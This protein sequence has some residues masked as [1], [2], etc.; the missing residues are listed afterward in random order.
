ML[1][2][3]FAWA[4]TPSSLPRP[5]EATNPPADTTKKSKPRFPVKTTTPITLDDTKK[6]MADLKDPDNIKEE[7]EY[8][9]HSGNYLIGTKIGGGYMNTPFMMTPQEYQEW[10]IQRS[11]RQ[12]YA[13]K[14]KEAFDNKEEKEFSF[15]NMQFS[16]GPAEKIFGPGGVQ[17][18]SSGS[19]EIKFGLNKKSVDNPSLP[20]RNRKTTG[21]DFD[22]Q[23][24]LSVL[25][26]IGDK[27]N[28]NLNY[29]TEATFD[30]DA[31]S[32][33]LQYDGKEDEIVKLIEA[34][35]VSFPSNNSLVRGSSS[36]FGIRT[37]LQFGKLQ[38]Q[39]VVSQKKGVSKSVSSSGGDQM[40]TFE[41]SADN[42]E[43]NRHFFLAHFFRDNYDK[44][45]AK[46]PNITSGITINRIEVWVTNK[47][48]TTTNTRNII[49]FTDLAESSHIGNGNWHS[50]GITQPC[51]NSNDLYSTINSSYADARVINKVYSTLGTISGFTGG[52]DY[53]KLESARLL[54]KTEY[55]LNSSLGYISL[56][57][58][59]QT[60]QVLAVAYEYTYRGQTYQVG[61]FSTDR[62]D[63]TECLYVKTLKNATNTPAMANW[64]LMMKN[65][66]SLGASSID[67]SKFRLDIKYLSDTSGVYITYL[68]TEKYKNTTLLK[69]LGMDRLD[70][71]Q[72]AHPNGYYD[73]VEGYTIDRSSGR[74]FLPAA[75]PFGSYFENII[76]DRSIS[77]NFVYNEL[78][79]STRTI[80]KQITEKNKFILTGQY[81]G[82]SGGNVI[83]L[84]AVN[85]PRG[86]VV[87]TAGGVTLTENIDYSVNYG[88]GEVTILNQSIIDAGT[89]VNVSLESTGESLERKT[90]LGLNWQY[91]FNKNFILGGTLMHL[92]EQ[93]LTSKVAMGNEPLS[94]TIMG[95]S[96][97]WKQNS[98]WLTDLIDKIPFINIT[99][100]SS[101]NFTAEFAKL[102]TGANSQSQGNASYIDDFE[103]TK[104]AID[105]SSPTDWV[106]SSCLLFF[107]EATYSNDVRY[108]YNRSLLSWYNIDPMF[109]R[110]SSSL[111]P[112]HIKSDLNQLSNH[113]VREV[114]RTELFPNKELT[115]GESSTLNILNLAY[116][117]NERGPYNLNTNLD[118]NGKL[119]NPKEHWGG[120][121]RALETTDFETAN[122]E[123]I[124]FWM[125]DPF[126]YTRG[127]AG[128]HG[129]ELYFDLG[130]ISE[131]ILKDGN[132]FY[133]SGMP[134]DGS[135]NYMES[136]WGRIPTENT[137]TY[138]FNTSSG[139]RSRQDIGYNGL[140]SD[141][142]KN[143]AIYQ[144]FL[145]GIQGK[146]SQA[147]YDSLA[148]DPAGDDYHYFRGSDYDEKRVSIMDRYKKINNPEGNSV[149]SDNSPESYSTA[150]KTIP[151]AEDI[152]QDYTLNEYNNYYEYRVRLAPD[153]MKVGAGYI[154]D[155]RQAKVPLRNGNTESISWYLFRI[156][157]EQYKSKKGNINDFS[158]IRFIR[159]FLTN[160]ENPIVLRFGTLELVRGEWR[161]YDL[162]LNGR[163][164]QTAQGT[165]DVAA[166]NI[167]ENNTKTPVNY[168]LPPG[169]SPVIDRTQSQL[170][171]NNEQALN[172]TVKRLPANESRAVYK[173]YNLDLR[174][175]KHIQMFAHANAL[176][177]DLTLKDY[178]TSV[179]IRI[180]TDYKNNYYEYDILL[181]LTAAGHYDR[182]STTDCQQ[183]W[184]EENM[185][186]IDLSL[187]TDLK[188][189]RNK[190]KA[191]G[192][193]SY[194]VPYYDYDPNKPNNKITVMGN[195]SL[196][197]IKTL[198]IGVRNN[199]HENKQVEVWVNELRLQNYSQDGGMAAR[200][201]L[202]IKISDLATISA[203]T[204][205]ETSGFG[206]LEQGVTERRNSNLYSY[207]ITSSIQLGKLFPEKA[208]V[209]API[210]YSYSKDKIVP[211]YNPLD[212][213][214]KLDDALSALPSSR[215]KDSLKNIVNTV[216][217]SK[218][219]SISNVKVDIAS[220][221]HPMPY[222]PANFSVSY[223]HSHLFS[224]GET[225]MW[226]RN[227]AWKL[228]ANYDYAP[229][230]EPFAPFKNLQDKKG[231]LR[232]L[233]EFQINWLPQNLSMSSEITRTYYELQERD[234]D[235]LEDKSI[236]L[237]FSSD[238]LWNRRM[239]VTWDITNNIHASLSTATN[240]EIVEP[241]V[242]NKSLYT[243]DY[244]MWK[245][246]VW[247]SVKHWGTPLTY[248]Q[249]FNFGWKL[250]LELIPAFTWISSDFSYDSS[251]GWERGTKLED[252]STLGNTINNNR[253]I[254]ITGRL[255]L[256][257]LYDK[258]PY[259]QK[260]NRYYAVK[261]AGKTS[262]KNKKETKTKRTFE[263]EVALS[264][265]S[266]VVL[267]HNL[268]TR[269]IRV[270]S[271]T[272]DG[273]RY[274]LKYKISNSNTIKILNKDSLTVK[275]T[276]NALKTG[277]N[278]N[279][280][281]KSLRFLARTA[282]MVRNVNISY[283]DRYAMNL[284]GFMP[285]AGDFFGQRRGNILS[286]GL[287]FAFGLTGDSY[288]D[289]ARERGWLLDNDSISNAAATS[290]NKDFQ[291]NAVLE[292]IAGLKIDMNATR[293]MNRSKS[294][295]YTFEN[296]PVTQSGS[297]N[298]TTIS[299][300]SAFESTGNADN[301]YKSKTFSRFISYL[302]TFQKRVEA[303]YA[304]AVYPAGSEHAGKTFDPANGTISQYS[305]DVMIPAFLAAY[306]GGNTSSPLDIFPS[307]ARMLPN[308]TLSYGGLAKLPGIK[309]HFKSLNI[310][311][312]YKSIFSIGS[313][314]SY[315]TYMDY[316]GGLGFVIDASTNATLPSSM[317]NV[318]T[319]SINEAFSPLLGVTATLQNDLT[320]SL[321]YNRTRVL[322]L[323]MT[324]LKMTE[325]VSKDIVVG[326]GYKINDLKIFKS[327]N[328]K[329]TAAKNK[330]KKKKKSNVKGINKDEDSEAKEDN[331]T[332]Q[333]GMNNALNLR[334][335][336]SFRD[337]SA[338]NRDI[339]TETS[340]ATSGNKA[341]KLSFT[342][343]YTL[344]KLLT[345]SAYYDYQ[346]T[347]PL[348]TSSSYPTTT[349]DFGFSM[350]FSLAR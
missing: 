333:T 233:Q 326:M 350:R 140:T 241:Y 265:D 239:N 346:T 262:A 232:I 147:V 51:N 216:T 128:E 1:L 101:I 152:N 185:L 310:D 191:L 22:E 226:E 123:Y 208:K 247:H 197:N 49:G 53:E 45:L 288:I 88:T 18:K 190:Q 308:W 229:T 270:R 121:M 11:M 150:Y 304:N 37:D 298:M 263:K 110:R 130:D 136:T 41:I 154:V 74:V 57:S 153:S 341:I 125:M 120:M 17:I 228:N 204:H 296:S 146:V 286:P 201:K 42:Y 34:G 260:T 58:T 195:P 44:A 15:T 283:S 306:C 174:Q 96:L 214:M 240:A 227:D 141:E 268:K 269:K 189:E 275:V 111:T 27:M 258:V 158:S 347:K 175:Y 76:G 65:V 144:D 47:N 210:Y 274:L 327:P 244:E 90:M 236:P 156:P 50:N 28:F 36:L 104:S 107:N 248:S 307:L 61:E 100:P 119:Q 266:T 151:D 348:L 294:I 230:F 114:Y 192:L 257:D 99:M 272:K 68:P 91:D 122:I 83:S 92:T 55:T 142:E 165:L 203:N 39:T 332:Q 184:P 318:N 213:D 315:S 127:T 16:L 163:A 297:F 168:I 181:K 105:I 71:N 145:A 59:L 198:M 276:V 292:P 161:N 253:N 3:G 218:N 349:Q 280:M 138:A 171:E 173:N 33:K 72:N 86:S 106:I 62:T 222:D 289:K 287:D 313:Y 67:R 284:P 290:S 277:E 219:F 133:E 78:Y 188:R 278:E 215:E 340:Q 331:T 328:Q 131:D 339:L 338:I 2:G 245:D 305:S 73:F 223:S 242:Q 126:I 221:T 250:P 295:F 234:M 10:S 299:I 70:N 337:Q 13:N 225:T 38:L 183:V 303:Q 249:S 237:S 60:D 267:Q 25:G 103:N 21:L 311:H 160:F 26:T 217:T 322:T 170:T 64:D 246:S 132:K 335:D 324:S 43:S 169:I 325:A 85:V 186:D 48:N 172:I 113:Y 139:S 281:T 79:D 116:Y 75:E 342:A 32:L 314:N 87:V 238:F 56:K 23:V 5:A 31:K 264:M 344:S 149:D 84:G 135:Q 166:V 40:T 302:P 98:Q 102:F 109:T 178:E 202:D 12:Y 235:N 4:Y 143:F 291:V 273:K 252:N 134:T 93:S 243:D 20:I 224:S 259:L 211:K 312:G 193:A 108:G 24:N 162:S 330:N 251:Y 207:G 94:N 118:V 317:Y 179:F 316:M 30:F 52:I 80:A 112:G 176:S 82:S 148:Q 95:L 89:A 187:F 155:S 77:N 180:G 7:E 301:G 319:V 19:A 329:A 320:F 129:G 46:L 279:F 164:N 177:G 54:N 206:G 167:Q 63:N 199:S 255:N 309:K 29:N 334:L 321:R 261:A 157:L 282:M 220:K 35:N 124:E 254:R 14:N 336:F 117:P 293:T 159:M 205:I 137:V 231:W 300:K 97:S 209:N 256:E 66:Y 285:N 194:S 115:V 9:E 323:S 343:E 200:A 81:K 6:K 345:M 271:I 69:L 196:G 182:Y 8:D 212:T